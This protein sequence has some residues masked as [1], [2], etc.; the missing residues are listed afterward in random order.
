MPLKIFRDENGENAPKTKGDS[1]G[2][3]DDLVGRFRSGYVDKTGRKDRPVGLQQWRV[4]TG[5]PSVADAVVDL[6]S[7][8][9]G[10]GEWE[11]SG[12]DNL[13]V[14][15]ES[16]SVEILLEDAR[17]LRQQM[18]MRTLKGVLYRSDGE[19]I[20]WPPEKKGEPDPQADQTFKERKAAS[21]DGT[22][23]DAQV[24][25]YFR[26]AENPDLGIFKFQSGAWTLVSDLS[27]N[28]TEEEIAEFFEKN[29]GEKLKA[30]LALEE[31][32]F[33]AKSGKM[34]G[35]TVTFT[36]PTITLHGKA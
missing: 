35:E 33:V 28:E 7:A 9:N 21:K 20:F 12:E 13:E 25:L 16:D 3:A 26:L 17:A 1:G 6:L 14:F 23:A 4:T 34:A 36:K 19:T 32:S 15:T 18:V 29:P 30:T 11:T 24:E 27:F 31:V 22:G 5:D 10:V 2:F 8:P